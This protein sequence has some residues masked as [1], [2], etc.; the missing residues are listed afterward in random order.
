MTLLRRWLGKSTKSS[1]KAVA[2]ARPQA[3]KPAV[4]ALE[5]REVPAGI[6]YNPFTHVLTVTGGGNDTIALTRNGSMVKATLDNTSQSFFLAGI[7]DI[8]VNTGAGNN[9]VQVVGL[10]D[11]PVFVTGAFGANDKVWVDLPSGNPAVT[12]A[13]V[14][15]NY[16]FGSKATLEVSD[17][18][19]DLGRYVTITNNAVTMQPPTGWLGTPGPTDATVKYAGNITS[20]QVDGGDSN[21][22]GVQST[23]AA[24]PLSIYAGT[25]FNYVGIG[26]GG[27]TLYGSP[28]GSL[29]AIASPVHVYDNCGKTELNV[30]DSAGKDNQHV[31][32]TDQSVSFAGGPTVFYQGK[33]PIAGDGVTALNIYAPDDFT[34]HSV[35]TVNSVSD[36][37]QLS[38]WG[39]NHYTVNG[40][41]ANKAHTYHYGWLT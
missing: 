14:S 35:F 24:T 10:S 33:S 38:L 12:N 36:N 29:A 28:N 21:S 18:S 1:R 34:D 41:A 7:K 13:L 26:G 22:F 11:V 30:D 4:E 25:G 2:S 37:T 17:Y 15:V 16:G 6:N 31:T 19:H 39:N 23:A 9:S 20:L 3:V 27:T 8:F 5:V 40:P 32:V